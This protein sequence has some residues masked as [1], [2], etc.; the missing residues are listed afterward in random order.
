MSFGEPEDPD[1]CSQSCFVSHQPS[2]VKDGLPF[3]FQ[4]L[5]GHPDAPQRGLDAGRVRVE[6]QHQPVGVALELPQLWLGE[7]SP[8]LCHHV[9]KPG[10][11]CLHHIHVSLDDDGPV[12]ATYGLSC[13]VQPVQRPALVEERRLGR[14]NVLGHSVWIKCPCAKADHAS[15]RITNGNH[16]PVAEAVV[17]AAAVVTLDEQPRLDQFLNSIPLSGQI[18]PRRLPPWEAVAQQELSCRI[19][20]QPTPVYVG[21]RCGCLW[22]VS[23]QMME[24]LGRRR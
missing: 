10:L 8:H 6:R 24:I 1:L 4:H 3:L 18:G 11:L 22:S 17:A 20:A 21:P 15:V 19:V 14:V 16:Q 7:C 12:L 9:R 5:T 2:W 13:L 23:E